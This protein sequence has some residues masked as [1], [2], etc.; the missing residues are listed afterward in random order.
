MP[1]FWCGVMKL[2]TICFSPFGFEF[3]HR[4]HG[5]EIDR[6]AIDAERLAEGTHP[7]VIL[8]KLL[9]A[10]QRAPGDQL[11]HVGIAGV[12]ADLF[13]FQARPGRRRNDLA[14]LRHHVAEADFLVFLRY[15]EMLVLEAGGLRQRLPC[16]DGHLA[17]RLGRKREDDFGGVDVGVDAGQPLRRAPPPSPRRSGASE[18]RLHARCSRLCLSRRCRSSA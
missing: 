2:R 11:V 17:V 16:L 5:L 8:V 6:R 14:R 4:L 13:G 9:A 18:A 15:G 7:Q 10:G 3:D 1:H 12:V